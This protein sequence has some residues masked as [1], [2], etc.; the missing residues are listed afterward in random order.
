MKLKLFLIALISFQASAEWVVKAGSPACLSLEGL[1]YYERAAYVDLH[2]YEV[3]KMTNDCAVLKED[4]PTMP[5]AIGVYTK[6][7]MKSY[8]N[9]DKV[10]FVNTRDLKRW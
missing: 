10:Y 7:E 3:L 8:E 4:T 2:K 1:K 6:A 9:K 5:Q